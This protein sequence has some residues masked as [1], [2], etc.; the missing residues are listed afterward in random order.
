ML[1]EVDKKG[2]LSRALFVK[3]SGLALYQG[4]GDLDAMNTLQ[5]PF[6]F[7]N[8]AIVWGALLPLHTAYPS[9]PDIVPDGSAEK[10]VVIE[11]VRLTVHTTRTTSDQ[12]EFRYEIAGAGGGMKGAWDRKQPK[13]WL[14]DMTIDD[15]KHNGPR[16]ISSLG[17]AR[18]VER[19]R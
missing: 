9:G 13:P 11:K 6:M 12:I 10:E 14:N 17:D 2:R 4:D 15:W 18:A 3:P 1:A 7:F 8:E 5:S 16:S 19:T